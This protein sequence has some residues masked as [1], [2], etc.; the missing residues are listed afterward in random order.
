MKY[1]IVTLDV[2]RDYGLDY[3]KSRQ[4]IDEIL[5]EDSNWYSKIFG[6]YE[7]KITAFIVG[8]IILESPDIIDSLLSC[9]VDLALHSYDHRLQK[10]FSGNVS[11]AI[12]VFK[13]FVGHIPL[14]YRAPQGLITKEDLSI[15]QR[16]GVKYDS[17]VFP[18]FRPFRYWNISCPQ[19]PYKIKDFDLIEFPIASVLRAR[20]PF[21]L[22]YVTML[23]FDF[24]RKLIDK[25]GLPE[26]L[27]FDLHLHDLFPSIS[28]KKLSSPL[29][30]VYKKI[31]NSNPRKH[32][33]KI[34]MMLRKEK[35]CFVN[36]SELYD[37]Y[38][39]HVENFF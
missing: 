29:K 6:A 13:K 1:A 28:F 39:K 16:R 15:L 9:E 11:E 23:G 33:G 27:V 24:Y 35:Y 30:L 36:M 22:S 21:T 2:E 19:N 5:L 25:Y 31:Y 26:I 17:S 10:P 34:L 14:G 8:Q 4:L 20:L 12:N 3:I 7:T 18:F 37:I 38:K 32:L